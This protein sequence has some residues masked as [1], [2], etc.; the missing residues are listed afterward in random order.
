MVETSNAVKVTEQAIGFATL[1]S[2]PKVKRFNAPSVA[3]FHAIMSLGPPFLY[4]VIS[5]M[6]FKMYTLDKSSRY[7]KKETSLT[8]RISF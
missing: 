2:P 3:F 4:F 5:F 1:E 6:L 8:L 7:Q